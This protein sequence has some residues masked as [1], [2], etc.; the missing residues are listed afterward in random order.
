[1]YTGAGIAVP[2]RFAPVG[3]FEALLVNVAVVDADPLAVGVNV[4]V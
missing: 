3:A 1:M 4:T 2:A